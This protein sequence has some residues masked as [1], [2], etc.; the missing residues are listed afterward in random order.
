[1]NETQNF[2]KNSPQGKGTNMSI[3]RQRKQNGRAGFTLIELLIVIAIIAILAGMLLP[4][5]N[6]ARQ[7]AKTIACV[8]KLKQLGLTAHY[9]AADNSNIAPPSVIDY[10]DAT[11]TWARAFP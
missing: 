6:K 11:Y 8:S 5:L 9:Y 4:A 1:M 2:Y 7:Q 10:P 3:T